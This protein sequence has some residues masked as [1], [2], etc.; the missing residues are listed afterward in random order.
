MIA[1][2]ILQHG[3]YLPAFYAY[4]GFAVI[5]PILAEFRFQDR[6][7]LGMGF[8]M[9]AYALGI[10]LIGRLNNRWIRDTLRLRIEQTAMSADL[11]AKMEE[12]EQVSLHRSQIF[13]DL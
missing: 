8:A 12:N 4:A 11:Q 10:G 9:A 6:S 7:S 1:G 3:A 13:R 5:P 2:A